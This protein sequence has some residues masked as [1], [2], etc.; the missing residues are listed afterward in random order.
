MSSGLRRDCPGAR[1]RLL[2]APDSNCAEVYRAYTDEYLS[3]MK[4][5]QVEL[6][7]C[8]V[9]CK[10][11]LRSRNRQDPSVAL[12]WLIGSIAIP[13]HQPSVGERRGAGR[14]RARRRLLLVNRPFTASAVMRRERK[15]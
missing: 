7:R 13:S 5:R 12:R 8:R 15:N 4:R 6:P 2:T 9:N 10:F 1:V 3:N 14:G 11:R